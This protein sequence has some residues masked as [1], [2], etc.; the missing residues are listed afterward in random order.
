MQFKNQ[1]SFIRSDETCRR[2]CGPNMRS[3]YIGRRYSTC[4]NHYA[5]GT[6]MVRYLSFLLLLLI[7]FVLEARCQNKYTPISIP[8][9]DGKTLAA[10]RYATD[11]TSARPVILIQT[12]Y[13][14]NYYRIAAALPQ[15]GGAFPYDSTDYN[16]VML[17]W[18]G[19]YGSTAAAV[20]NYDRGLDGYDAVEWIAQ[21]PW[22]NGKIGTWGLSA[23]GQIQFMTAR[24]HPPHLVCCVPVVK[25]YKTKYSDY[26]YGGVYRKEHVESLQGLGFLT[27]ATILA[28]PDYTLIWK[29]IERNADYPEDFSVPMLVMSGWFDHYPDD[30][31]RAFDDIRQRSDAAVRS[32]HKLIMGPWLHSEIGKAEQGELVFP[33]AAG[34]P[35]TEALRFFDF[36]MRNISNGF[37]TEPVIR[38]YQ[39]GSD[40]WRSAIRWDDIPR[41]ID[42]L[43]LHPDRTLQWT[44]PTGSGSVSTISYN[45]RD[46]SPSYGAARF[47]PF[48]PTVKS[49]PLDIRQ[50]VES[51][52]DALIFT[53]P[54]F[55]TAYEINGSVQVHLFVSSDRTDTDFSIRICDVSPDGRS[56]I[57]TDGIRRLRFRDSYEWETLME[58]NTVYALTIELQNLA[59][60]LPPGHRFRIVVSSS[61]YPRFDINL[62]NGGK[63]Y[64]AG[65]TL[66]ATNNVFHDRDHASFVTIATSTRQTG[67]NTPP[68]PP[69][70]SFM[71]MY[72][73][74]ATSFTA[75]RFSLDH[76]E[77]VTIRITDIL[78]RIAFEKQEF[79]FEGRHAF[80]LNVSGLANGVYCCSVLE[81]SPGQ[82]GHNATPSM[83]R[84][85]LPRAHTFF[86]VAR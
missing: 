69:V 48:D 66:I 79:F 5:Y 68:G 76:P 23:L 57:M 58:P 9:R 70:P 46:P 75:V 19:F 55:I 85:T 56:M 40:E 20:P 59:L 63:M 32:Q 81:G 16:Y 1:E 41:S 11:T 17:D 64:V 38:Y 29:T 18:R 86:R 84:R 37:E 72:P 27:T 47:N 34:I 24:H 28:Q 21:Q 65:D 67:T 80:G 39:M 60:T 54:E 82:H 78:G 33:N 77:I 13:N 44:K 14:K 36:T 45:P 30:V 52:A 53:T 62:N 42:T 2:G 35:N 73:N 7:A 6:H 12:P 15:A 71:G 74:P 51:R 4:W 3:A 49:G 10:D 31:L 83:E 22:C 26:Y 43:F 61:D 8:M 50:V 25:D